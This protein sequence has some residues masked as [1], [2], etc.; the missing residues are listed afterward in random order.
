MLYTI[1]QSSFS[2]FSHFYSPI[3]DT[4]SIAG[5]T[6]LANHIQTFRAKQGARGLCTKG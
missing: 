1:T 3:F 2:L 5:G 6:D 4:V